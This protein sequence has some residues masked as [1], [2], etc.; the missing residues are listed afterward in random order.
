LGTNGITEYSVN[1]APQSNLEA[2]KAA[3]S[4]IT[5]EINKVKPAENA[6]VSVQIQAEQ[7]TSKPAV[8]P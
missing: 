2:L 6:N 8:K 5:N 4:V 3:T 1:I 7:K